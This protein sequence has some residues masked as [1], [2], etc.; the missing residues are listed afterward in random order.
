MRRSRNTRRRRNPMPTTGAVVLTNGRRRFNGRKARHASPYSRIIAKLNGVALSNRKRNRKRRNPVQLL[1]R[2][3]RNGVALSNRR[4]RNGVA[5]SNRRR[6][7]V[8]LLNGGR[9]RRFNRHRRNPVQLLNRR[10]RRNSSTELASA[11]GTIF[12]PIQNLVAKIPVVGKKIAPY[13]GPIL[14]GAA[15]LAAVYFP[16]KYGFKY[17]P[18]MVKARIAPI[19]FTTSGIAIGLALAALPVGKGKS[20]T[21]L[22][23]AMPLVG[24]VI[25]A[26]R[27][28][29]GSGGAL[30]A[31]D[32]GDE[33]GDGGLWQLGA[34]DFGDAFGAVEY[35][36]AEYGAVQSDYADAELSDAYYSGGD[37][38]AAEG[39]A[40]LAGPRT[41]RSRFPAMKRHVRIQSACS[42]HAGKHGGRW[43]WLCK[44]VGFKNF[45]KVVAMPAPQRVAYIKKMR[46][47]AIEQLGGQ[48]ASSA[49]AAQ[50]AQHVQGRPIPA[51]GTV[52]GGD[53]GALLYAGG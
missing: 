6:N 9:S 15:G 29:S 43:A 52:A 23:A 32:L 31:D 25:D 19:A 3:R 36:D 27:Y 7:P 5:L 16:V 8:Q 50:I 10:R 44:L 17:L 18:A 40:A 46:A 11:Q 20:K 39:E 26:Y 1:N 47:Y 41:W 12:A 13:I 34:D 35:G 33:Y 53:Y 48:Q 42:R 2:R 4:R 38:D 22:V 51:A 45:Q 37:L 28:F 24:A 49:A 14:F 30:G 21:I